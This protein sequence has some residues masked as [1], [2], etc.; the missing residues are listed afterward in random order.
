MRL[1]LA[2]NPPYHPAHGGANKCNRILAELLA[3]RGH[4]VRAVTPALGIPSALTLETLRDTLAQDGIAVR[5]AE[6]AYELAIRGVDLHAVTHRE[7]LREHVAAEIARFAPDCVIVSSE[8]P[9][10]MLLQT[11]LRSCPRRVVYLLHTPSFLPFGPLAFFPGAKRA[12]L[13]RDVA[14]IVAPSRFSAAYVRQWGRLD[15]AVCHLPVYGHG[16]F[17]AFGSPG[18]GFVTLV[19]AC[20]YKGIDIFI[21]LAETFPGVAFAAVPTWGTTTDDLARLRCL[22]NVT[23]LP[24]C[25][26]IDEIFRQTRVLLM[27]SLWLENFPIT[28]VEAMARGI[29]VL[30]SDV[31]G[32]PEAKLGTNFVLPVRPIERFHDEFDENQLLQAD[33]PAQDIGPWSDALARLLTDRD[34][35]ERESA[36]AREAAQAF[37]A[38]LRIDPLESVLAGVAHARDHHEND[39]PHAEVV[40]NERRS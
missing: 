16:P 15:A 38:T 18:R 4:V 2:M 35:Y 20:R 9:S 29:P 30:A 1:L 32:I 8:D 3:G 40:L 23:I 22:A 5:Q 28:L 7:R 21:A 39:R 33:V 11:A 37:V 13:F 10:Q 27:P 34:L 12:A 26:D 6:G 36:S 17:P 24:P 25:D 14:R 19:N 31:G